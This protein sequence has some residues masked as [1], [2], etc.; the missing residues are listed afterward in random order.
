MRLRRGAIRLEADTPGP[1]VVYIV[2]RTLAQGRACGLAS[3]LDVA[4]GNRSNALGAALGLTAV[5]LSLIHI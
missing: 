2:A 5:F 3:V 1:A 4:L